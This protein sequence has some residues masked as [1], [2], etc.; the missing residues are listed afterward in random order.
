MWP[1]GEW[2]G[3]RQESGSHREG[4]DGLVLF[5]CVLLDLK[6]SDLERGILRK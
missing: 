6:W 2:E 5:A 4:S 1:G 3:P